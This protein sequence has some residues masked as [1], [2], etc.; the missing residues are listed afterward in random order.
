MANLPGSKCQAP[1]VYKN[2]DDI[3]SYHNA[4]VL[5]IEDRSENTKFEDIMV[6]KKKNFY[7]LKYF[8]FIAPF[9]EDVFATTLLK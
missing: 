5:S 2:G 6:K 4:L 1:Y 9:I 3:I 7:R 8:L